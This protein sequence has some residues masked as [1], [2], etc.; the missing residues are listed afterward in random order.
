MDNTGYSNNYSSSYGCNNVNTG[1]SS[2]D[3]THQTSMSAMTASGMSGMTTDASINDL[4]NGIG[5]IQTQ[6][7]DHGNGGLCGMML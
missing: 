6:V 4:I 5:Q 7:P 3:S 2:M 1:Y